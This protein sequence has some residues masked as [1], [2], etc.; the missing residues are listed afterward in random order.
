M[1]RRGA[2]IAAVA[3]ACA[4]L[5]PARA[6][7]QAGQLTLTPQQ[8]TQFPDR[9]FVLTLPN[10]RPVDPASVSV[11]ENGQPVDGVRVAP[12]QSLEQ[13]GVVLVID[14]SDS[15]HGASIETAFAAARQFAAQRDPRQPL[16]VVAFNNRATVLLPFTTNAAK[17]TA[18]L[19]TAPRLAQGT[20][21]LDAAAQGLSLIGAAHMQSGSVVIM[22]DGADT[23]SD[24][25]LAELDAT[26]RDERARVYTVGLQSSDFQ[27]QLLQQ[28]AGVTGGSYTE[29]SSAGQLTAIYNALGAALANQYLLGYRSL[30]PAAATVDV[31][32]TVDGVAG[33][34]TS[35]YQTP[36]L[37][38][39]A[40]SSSSSTSR[41]SDFIHSWIGALLVACLG[42]CL[43]AFAVISIFQPRSRALR[44]RVGG[45]VPEA[46]SSSSDTSPITDAIYEG[47]ERALGGTPWWN[48]F[49]EDVE[50]SGL[51]LSPAQ[52]IVLGLTA[53]VLFSALLVLAFDSPI[54]LLM[55][56]LL[57]VLACVLASTRADR[58]RFE[59]ASQLPDNL[60][61]LASAL[62][63][64]HSLISA[65]AV[66]AED[67]AE[68]SRTEF[69]RVVAEER[70]G[71]PVD[72]SIAEVGRRMNSREVKQ[73]A[74]VS[75]V[76][77]QTGGNTAEILDQVAIN[78]R[79]RFELKRL[80]RTLT[81]QG[82]VSRWIVTALPIGLFLMILFVNPD[83]V[84][85]L[86]H[87]T[88]GHILLVATAVMNVTGSYTIGR[89]VKVEV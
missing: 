53:G 11:T 13:A 23:G 50:I 2:V 12:L 32:V 1:S 66:M 61:V 55:I 78:V 37:A 30:Q 72:E 46:E 47:T 74:L 31:R 63:A 38:A 34:A 67:A 83:Y 16:A 25:T 9:T 77:A 70:I 5:M 80:V 84:Q 68:P 33:G 29:A 21:I 28:I 3:V 87:T 35:S 86:L 57:P 51:P 79:A 20:H 73:I 6:H 7:A 40:P 4:V 8:G 59:F 58:R 36:A 89:I 60:Q 43:V 48:R 85:P 75:V 49:S 71:V 62:R 82:R 14:A 65:M 15:M 44:R 26:A 42:G 88:A 41:F 45:F 52:V 54:L 81:A 18:A 10:G 24:E 22:S 27:P 69:K 64:G 76:Q 17:I 56:P 39:S 19:A